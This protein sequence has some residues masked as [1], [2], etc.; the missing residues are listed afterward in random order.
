[1][2]I[3][4]PRTLSRRE[5]VN[6]NLEPKTTSCVSEDAVNE[7]EPHSFEGIGNLLDK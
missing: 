5:D 4:H 3:T 2:E 1:M 6:A 7:A